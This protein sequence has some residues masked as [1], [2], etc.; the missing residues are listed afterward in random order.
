VLGGEAKLGVEDH[1]RIQ[2]DAYS[3]RAER[4]LPLF[5]GWTAASPEVER[6]RAA[7]AG[8]D[9]VLGRES[10]PAAIYVRWT[11]AADE[12]AIAAA[13][14]AE[15]P[16]LMESALA[17]AIARMTEEWGPDWSE[18]RYGRINTTTLP[19]M[20]VPA[21]D[22]EPVERPGAFG[23]VNADGANF[24]RVI[25]LS[26]LDNSVWTNAPGQSG[27]PGS[28]FYGNMRE[29]LGNGEYVPLLFSRDRVEEGAA[30]RLTLRPET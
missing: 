4:D 27:Q 17:Q 19:H 12:D 11:S 21:F 15:R 7:V 23:T 6:A 28:P 1:M 16:A 5:Q 30:Y 29:Y 20:F 18:W 25:D 2:Q 13:A 10:T 8:W 3:L 26:N 14:P 24:R 22:L 9:K